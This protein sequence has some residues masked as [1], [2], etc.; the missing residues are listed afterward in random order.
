MTPISWDM[1]AAAQRRDIMDKK[2][3]CR[4]LGLDCDYTVCARTETEVLEKVV[5]HA[6]TFHQMKGFSQSLYNKVKAAIQDGDC[7]S[8]ACFTDTCCC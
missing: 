6:Q 4:D 3:S 7:D 5:D 1:R 8:E 2:F